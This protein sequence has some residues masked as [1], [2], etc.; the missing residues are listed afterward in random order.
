MRASHPISLQFN[1]R[2]GILSGAP[3]RQQ[4]FGGIGLFIDKQG[5]GDG[6]KEALNEFTSGSRAEDPPTLTPP[7]PFPTILP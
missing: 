4:A 2:V 5:D 3:P 6:L 1:G 7:T